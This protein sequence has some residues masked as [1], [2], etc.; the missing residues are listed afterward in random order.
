MMKNLT[1]RAEREAQ[2]LLQAYTVGNIDRRTV[3]RFP[4]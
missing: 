2:R 3:R 4:G 1:G